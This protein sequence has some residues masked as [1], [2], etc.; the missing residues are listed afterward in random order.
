VNAITPARDRKRVSVA[1]HNIGDLIVIKP[2][3][4][5]AADAD[6][7]EAAFPQSKIRTPDP[8]LG[9]QTEESGSSRKVERKGW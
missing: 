6:V 7:T 1:I 3:V 2:A 9:L 8:C 5:R 4:P